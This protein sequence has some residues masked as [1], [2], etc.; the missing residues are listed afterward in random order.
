MQLVFL[1]IQI[2]LAVAI[3]GSVLL[4][5]NG[6]DGLGNLGGGS[7]ISGSSIVSSRTTA[8]FLSKATT[9]LMIC[10][11]VNSLM[12]GNLAVRQHK[13]GSV[14]EKIHNKEATKNVTPQVP[15]SE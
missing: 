14:V 10:F 7:G 6:G 5:K 13:R 2:I 4:Q 3:I 11:M 9:I 1:V 12:L 15:V 8:G